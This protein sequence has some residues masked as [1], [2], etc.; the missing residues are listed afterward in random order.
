MKKQTIEVYGIVDRFTQISEHDYLIILIES[1]TNTQF[2][3]VVSEH[4]LHW[5][6]EENKHYYA[7]G[8]ASAG[9]SIVAEYVDRWG[10]YCDHCGRHHTEGYYV[11]EDYYACSEECAI[12]LCGSKQEFDSSI[13]LDENGELAEN[14]PTYW[15]E[16]E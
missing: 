10:R 15:T 3:I 2:E 4:N 9:N 8:K 16:W 13:W 12:A 7:R 14:S 6:L 11:Y 1:D 5:E